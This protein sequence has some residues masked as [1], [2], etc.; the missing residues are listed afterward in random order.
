MEQQIVYSHEVSSGVWCRKAMKLSRGK[1][2]GSIESPMDL[3]ILCVF[4]GIFLTNCTSDLTIL[5]SRLSAGSMD[6]WEWGDI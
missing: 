3:R 5:W 6:Q 2:I 1:Q 4:P